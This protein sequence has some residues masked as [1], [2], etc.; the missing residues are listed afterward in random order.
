MRSGKCQ[1]LPAS[2]IEGTKLGEDRF[3][4]VH[5]G[6]NGLTQWEHAAKI[7]L[8]QREYELREL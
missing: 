3:Q 6:I 8:G 4:M 2:I 7:G 5:P 1:A